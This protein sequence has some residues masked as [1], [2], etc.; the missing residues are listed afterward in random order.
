M[1]RA[2]SFFLIEGGNIK[3]D[4]KTPTELKNGG[5]VSSFI[6]VP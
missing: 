6:A 1:T 3:M 2:S 4:K 5:I